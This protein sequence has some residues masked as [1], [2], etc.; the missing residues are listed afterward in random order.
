VGAVLNLPIEVIYQAIQQ[1][2]HVSFTTRQSRKGEISSWKAYAPA[3]AG[4]LAI[5]AVDRAMRGETSPSPIY[6]GEDSVIAW[7]LDGPHAHYQV[8][9][10][11][12]GEPKRAIL[13]SFTKQH[14]AE[15]QAQALIDL[16]FRMR[17]N[18]ADRSQI[19]KIVIHTS[20]HTHRV[21]GSGSHDPQKLDPR[22]SRETLDHSIM[23]IFAVALEDGTWHHVDSYLPERRQRDATL[24]LW[25]SITT[26][27][28]NKWTERY[29]AT[30][31]SQRAFGGRVE[32]LFRDG[33]RME[34]EIAV[35]DAH[36]LGAT[37]LRHD[38]YL[39]KFKTLADQVISQQEQ[40]RFTQAASTAER[41]LPGE[42]HRLNVALPKGS[43]QQGRPGI[44]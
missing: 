35:A 1:S 33:S 3:H 17:G 24:R 5:E 25:R 44:F 36:P 19:E 6:E 41:L 8:P 31:R 10:P 23:Y 38:G 39:H 7:M 12:P 20:A 29:H 40:D 22:A 4:K 34:D 27:E 15:Y 13:E 26:R 21:I 2:V 30:D 43:L 14:S 16:A 42:L 11:A 28:D 37:P 18:I 9:L 32:I